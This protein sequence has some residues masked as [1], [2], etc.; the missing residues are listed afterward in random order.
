MQPPD[1]RAATS[2]ARA[3]ADASDK[4]CC[5][6]A[7]AGRTDNARPHAARPAA[8]AAQAARL[9]EQSDQF[10]RHGR[11]AE[12]IATLQ[13]AVALRDA[14]ASL[15]QRLGT[16]LLQGG[17]PDA[18]VASLQSAIALRP[19]AAAS[20]HALA[21]ALNMCG[22]V[23]A[24]IA[25]CRK[26]VALSPRLADAH[27][28]LGN[29]LHGIGDRAGALQAF[30]QAAAAARGTTLGRMNQAK[31]LM[32]MERMGEAEQILRQAA[33]LD[34]AAA[35]A[36][37][38]LGTLLAEAGQFG[39]A[40]TMFEA[41]LAIDPS[42]V[43]I[44]HDMVQCKR[45]IEG[46]RPLI[47]R[48]LA[49]LQ[50]PLSDVQ[51]LRLHFALGKSFDDL[52]DYAAAIRH[53]D[54]ANQIKRRL[55]PFDGAALA[56][57]VDAIIGLFTPEYLAGHAGIG[58][59]SAAPLL[60]IGMPRSGTTLVE[61]TLSSHRTWARRANSIS[62]DA[63]ETRG[64]P[65]AT[66]PCHPGSSVNWRPSTLGIL[67]RAAP[68]RA[69]VT[70]KLPFNFFWAG[71][72]HLVFPQAT[73]LHCRRHPIDT[74][75]SIYFTHFAQRTEFA[76]RREDLVFCF[77]QYERLVAHWRSVLPAD[78]LLDIDYATLITE[79]NVSTRRLLEGAGLPWSDACLHPE[80]NPRFVRTA[81]VWQARQPVYT[82]SLDRHRQYNSWLGALR[83]LDPAL[84]E[85]AAQ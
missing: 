11:T 68:A 57:K 6:A 2:H 24:A 59:A 79:R 75:L 28:R 60:V 35:E 82:S 78:R 10:A 62:G 3:A 77:R 54:A 80:Q 81:T 52:G 8:V 9:A 73:F 49:R 53:F 26:A 69:R 56:R 76:A 23:D 46:D 34:P 17:R 58:V 37:R 16:L 30:E 72:I 45:I 74:C 61:Q 71:L 29:M 39:E 5:G 42:Q 51:R 20:H 21:V 7:T 15:H 18:A 19:E 43:A 33:I 63:R 36:R 27:S 85:S 1:D 32:L 38:V 14:D 65:P 83:D 50:G 70:D 47:E 64:W 48:M 44:Y 13:S 84:A 67:A 55:V 4:Q 40:L 31:A 25:A 22:Q 66:R 12:A 41:S